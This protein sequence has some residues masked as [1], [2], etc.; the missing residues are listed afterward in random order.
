MEIY[1]I[2]NKID[3]SKRT[4]REALNYQPIDYEA[5]DILR[6]LEGKRSIFFHFE[7]FDIDSLIKISSDANSYLN[8]DSVIL[9]NAAKRA[10]YEKG[11]SEFSKEMLV[12]VFN[13]DG[14]DD[15]KEYWISYNS[16]TQELII[17]KAVVIKRD[18]SEIKADINNNHIVFKSLEEN[19][20]IYMKWKINNYYS[21]KLTNHFWDTFYFNCFYPTKVIQ[22]SLFVT[23]NSL[24]FNT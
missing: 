9:L 3:L 20:F 16:Y 11:A 14:I 21:G 1:R 2:Q 7:T 19:D 10:V 17:E 15:F 18:I 6:E 22:Y 24:K 12:K 8:D 4:Y 23:E 13:N 5:R